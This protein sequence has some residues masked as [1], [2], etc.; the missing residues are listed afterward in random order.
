M[1]L[2]SRL[3]AA[4]AGSREL[5]AEI[6]L[7]AGFTPSW[8]ADDETRFYPPDVRSGDSRVAAHYTTSL[9][10]ITTLIEA[11]GWTYNLGGCGRVPDMAW[12]WEQR[13]HPP[14]NDETGATPALALC[15]ALAAAEGW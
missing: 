1:S 12:V 4:T 15:A 10:A 7:A 5:D 3:R 8:R 13:T 9:D 6:A 14:R 2:S 11:R